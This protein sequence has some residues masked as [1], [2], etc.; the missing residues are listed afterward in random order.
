MVVT[1]PGWRF[2]NK[3]SS[4]C[5]GSPHSTAEWESVT[6]KRQRMLF[7]APPAPPPSGNSIVGT[8]DADTLLSSNSSLPAGG[9]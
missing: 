4:L 3:M 1:V 7:S 6:A 8:G 9:C 5:R 2:K